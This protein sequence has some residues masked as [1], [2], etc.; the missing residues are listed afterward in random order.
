M[1]VK[2]AVKN[3]LSIFNNLKHAKLHNRLSHAYLFYGDEGVGKKEMAY[4]LACL[5]YCEKD[6]CLE[7]DTC[8]SILTGNHMNVNYIGIE[9]SKTMISKEQILNL[10]DEFSKTSLI[11]GSRIYIVD[12]IDTAS[13]AAQNSLLKFIEDPNNTTSTIGIFLAREISNV[14]NTIVSRCA[15]QHFKAIPIDKSISF[16]VKK[17][18][19]YL[20]AA[21]VMHLTNNQESALAMINSS[22]FISIKELFLDFINLRK[23]KEGVLYFIN[24]SNFFTNA[25]N[26]TIL[27]DWLLLFLEDAYMCKSNPDGLILKPL[28]DKIILYNKDYNDL[29]DK[30]EILLD[31]SNR[32][33]YN[34]SAKNVFHEL[35]SKLI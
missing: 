13:T 18:I 11:S 32:L 25:K 21:L 33:R 4:A 17:G 10:Q 15:L 26:L 6:G 2:E 8:K 19:D 34:V 16:L 9:D 28:Y 22:D 12:G 27:I 29:K 30:L 24:N 20:D 1:N 3:Q 7:C 14:V 31:L 35:I 23:S 5:L